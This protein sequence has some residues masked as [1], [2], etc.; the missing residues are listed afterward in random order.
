MKNI[1][2]F[3]ELLTPVEEQVSETTE[4]TQPV[5]EQVIEITEDEEVSETTE[6]AETEEVSETTEVTEDEEVSE[7][8]EVDEITEDEEISIRKIKTF[9]QFISPSEETN[10][11]FGMGRT[12][13]FIKMLIN[14][15]RATKEEA[16]M[17]ADQIVAKILELNPKAN[18]VAVLNAIRTKATTGYAEIG[19]FKDIKFYGNLATK[20]TGQF[21][22]A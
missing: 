2:T 4:T 20:G 13:A 22:V 15:Y 19:A 10:E 11:I 18:V 3:D 7:T 16:K 5:E 12:D 14:T 8:T 21:N 17:C 6:V 1:R 9:E